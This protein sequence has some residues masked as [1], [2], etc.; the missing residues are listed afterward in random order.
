MC[1]ISIANELFKYLST[2]YVLDVIL[3]LGSKFVKKKEMCFSFLMELTVWWKKGD[4]KLYIS[5]F[6][7][8]IKVWI[9]F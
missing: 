6:R 9:V 3:D 8:Q 2:Y 1:L 5:A 4:D 7:L